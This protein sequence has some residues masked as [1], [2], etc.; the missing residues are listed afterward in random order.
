MINLLSKKVTHIASALLILLL[1]APGLAAQN[2]AI[3][4]TVRDAEGQPVIGAAVVVAGQ[5]SL[6]V[7]TDTDGKYAFSVPAGATIEVS[8]IGYVSQTAKVGSKSTYDFI[9]AED[10]QLLEETVVIGYGVQKKSDL[11]GSVASVKSTDLMNRSTTDAAAALQGKAAGVHVINNGAP[12]SGSSIRVRGYSSNSGNLSPLFI[13]DG[14][15]VSSIQYLDPSMIESI[16]VLKDAASAAIYGAEAGNGVVLVTTKSGM[17]GQA[18]VNYSS[19]AT[20]QTFTKR[21]VMNRAELVDY[22]SLKNGAEWVKNKI[23]DFDYSHPYYPGGVIDQD[24][25]SAY[26]EPTWSQQHS[27]SFAGG[28]KKGHFFASLN[29]VNNNGVVRGDKDV[30]TRLSAQINADYQLFKW[31]TIGTNTSLEKW[32]TKSVS[33]REYGSSFEQML[34]IDPLT[35][36]YWTSVDEMSLDIRTMYNKVQDG[37]APRN[38]R[39]LRDENGW[40]AN[41]KYSD[42]EGSPFSKRDGTDSSNGGI[43]INGTLFANLTPIKGLI[44][45]SRLGYRISQSTSHSYTAPYYIGS[46]GSVDN[47]N[48]SASANTGYYYQ[49]ENFA[50]YSK[51]FGKHDL[52]AMVGMSYRENNS[53]GVSGSSSGED[54]LTSYEENFRYLNYLK[55]DAS[56]SVS[57][58]PNRSASLAYFGRLVYS[59]DNRYSIQANF[60]ADAFD[61]SKLPPSNRWGYFPSV[62]AGWTVSNESFIKDNID[63]NILSFLKVRA[64]WGQ[65]GNIGVLRNY[66]YATTISLGN[67]WYQYHVDKTGTAYGSSPAGLPNP[68]LKWETSEQIDLG[69]DAR[70]LGDRLTVGLDYY[71]K[72]TKDLLVSVTTPPELGVGSTIINGGGVLNR[73]LEFELGWK[74]SAGDFHYSINANLS[75]LHNEVTYLPA[76]VPRIESSDAQSTNYQIRTAFEP[77]YP[78]WYLLGY[79]YDGVDE[80][81]GDYILRDVND[82]GKINSDDMTYIGKG[83]P[84]LTYGINI[85]LAW[86]G[87]DFSLYG[88]GVAGNSIMPVL[89]RTGFKNTLRYY[90]EVSRTKANPN[91]YYPHPSKTEGKYDFWSS[92][93]NVFKGDFFR[94]KQMQLGYTLPSNI[95]RKAAISALRFYVSLD[96]FFTF[97]SYPGL[98]PE[99]ASTNST[100][101]S[102]LDWGSYPTMQK[103]ILGVNLT[104]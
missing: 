48:I 9:L 10:S 26:T 21:P 81:T 102:G 60:R 95:T 101:G 46:R 97:T 78:V 18:T 42:L 7:M 5:Q 63:R 30:Y 29:Y 96:D 3:S 33:Q 75:T 68:N 62:S 56:K 103:L 19:K 52:S 2:R 94:I 72:R 17:D 80:K 22:L 88:A 11:T 66:P 41:T 91:G 74:D 32:S 40:Y 20:L 15:Q 69:L 99:T 44:I 27:I 98:D 37:T 6:G 58:A 90:S 39:F 28:N 67:S 4:G 85:N 79:I 59:Y 86:K 73:G 71:D 8:C 54:I 49:W 16:E 64:S 89:H 25:I 53:D 77:G 1:G 92:S 51:T 35:P 61:S 83:N 14:L 45:T 24:W 82:D 43:N 12:G 38:Y 31:L 34:V 70:L 57:N 93:A 65:N 87:F 100:S 13:V 36:V 84:D 50:N 23:K 47:Y 76:G 104:F 55:S